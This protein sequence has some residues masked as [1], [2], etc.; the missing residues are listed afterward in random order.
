MTI[1]AAPRRLPWALC[2]DTLV[3][4]S[5]L[6]AAKKRITPISRSDDATSWIPTSRPSGLW[7]VGFDAGKGKSS[8]AKAANPRPKFESQY[9]MMA[10]TRFLLGHVS[11]KLWP[12]M[13]AEDRHQGKAG[14]LV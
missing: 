12:P 6:W 13:L 2:R 9:I 10:D 4:P 3:K 14:E 11:L 8:R 1:N 5:L 7:S